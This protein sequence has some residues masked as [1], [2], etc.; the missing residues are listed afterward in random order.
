MDAATVAL[1]LLSAFSR[2]SARDGLFG[3]PDDE[4]VIITHHGPVRY[5]PMT[6]GQMNRPY[7]G[8]TVAA[9]GASS[10]SAR[11]YYKAEVIPLDMNTWKPV[12][13]G[14]AGRGP[15]V[16]GG[17]GRVDA[18]DVPL[19][20]GYS[21]RPAKPLRRR[22]HEYFPDTAVVRGHRLQPSHGRRNRR[23][24]QPVAVEAGLWRF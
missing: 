21:V 1:L 7:D 5:E 6:A 11:G 19:T 18:L 15:V 8:G 17:S 23:P 20:V 22:R 13:G 24:T 10:A 14:W 4:H 9:A 2:A 16:G 12:P 3:Y